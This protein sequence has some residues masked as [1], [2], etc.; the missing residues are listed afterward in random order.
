MLRDQGDGAAVLR[1]YRDALAIVERLA[2]V[3]PGNAQWQHDRIVSCVKLVEAAPADARAW[4]A[5]ALGI[6]RDLAASGRLAPVDAGMPGALER[7]IA[8]LGP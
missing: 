1:S 2:A 5:R 7:R 6:A 4:L 8:A 3:D